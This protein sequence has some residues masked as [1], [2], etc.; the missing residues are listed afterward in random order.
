MTALF[1]L[2]RREPAR[3]VAF[4]TVALQLAVA[5]GLGITTEQQGAIVAFVTAL[6]TFLG[7]EIT[8]ANVYAP[9][10]VEEIDD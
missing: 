9:S 8:R 6:L 4:V 5:F 3:I 2:W 7:A 1:D 10:S